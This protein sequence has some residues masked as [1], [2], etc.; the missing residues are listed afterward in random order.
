MMRDSGECP[1]CQGKSIWNNQH[2]PN[3]DLRFVKEWIVV[4]W[5]RWRQGKRK[6]AFK[7]EYVCLDCGY[8]E[9]YVSPEG[10]DIIKEFGYP[11]KEFDPRIGE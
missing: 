11:E 10:L 6:F 4:K 2:I 3:I 1:K 9:S 7:D 8:S 5:S